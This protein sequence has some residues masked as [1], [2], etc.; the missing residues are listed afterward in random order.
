MLGGLG[1]SFLLPQQVYLFLLS[2]GGFALLFTYVV[3]LATHYK[4][5]KQRGCPPKGNCQLPGYPYTSW[6][7]L[8]S[9][10]A[11]IA[12]MPLIP[13]QGSGLLAGIMLIALFV[14]AY[15]VKTS[16]LNNMVQGPR[17][18]AEGET[19]RRLPIRKLE[20]QFELAEELLAEQPKAQQ[21]K[22]Q[23]SEK[24]R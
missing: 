24:N 12:S 19:N 1:L 9:S 5:R 17:T 16:Y 7:A 6:L 11:I 2:S 3:I 14:V 8:I 13:G 18:T 23:G 20:T 21:E 4:Y 10:I 22:E 15:F